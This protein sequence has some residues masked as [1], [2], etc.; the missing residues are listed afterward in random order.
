M[1]DVQKI[2]T[3]GRTQRNPR[4]PNW[5]ITDMI[6][7]YALSVIGEAIP[8]TYKEVEISSESKMWKDIMIKEMSSLQKNDTWKLSKLPKEKKAIVCKWAFA[9]KQGSRDGDTIRYKARLVV[10]GYVQREGIEYKL[11]TC[12]SLFKD[13]NWKLINWNMILI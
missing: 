13:T 2:I 3:I 12:I 1:S 9:K 10:K 6:V 5:L 11:N 4:K 7:V 8:S